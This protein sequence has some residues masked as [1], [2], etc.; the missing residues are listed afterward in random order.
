MLFVGI[1]VNSDERTLGEWVIEKGTTQK[2]A[3]HSQTNMNSLEVR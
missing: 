3:Y 1:V 2:I